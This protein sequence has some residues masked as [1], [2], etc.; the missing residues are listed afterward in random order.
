MQQKP[1]KDGVLHIYC[2][3][4]KPGERRGVRSAFRGVALTLVIPPV[5]VIS[6]GASS[7]VSML[8]PC[9]K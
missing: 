8:N 4:Y 6:I 5:S 3:S 9:S 2:R 7:T 1:G